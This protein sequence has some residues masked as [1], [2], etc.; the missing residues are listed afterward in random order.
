MRLKD[1]WARRN[2]SVP[3]PAAAWPAGLFVL[4]NHDGVHRNAARYGRPL[5]AG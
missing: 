5:I 4:A 3:A 1:D 2:V